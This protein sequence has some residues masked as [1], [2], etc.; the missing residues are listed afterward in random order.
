ML[1]P[2]LSLEYWLPPQESPTTSPESWL[3]WHEVES[4]SLHCCW[5][6]L[7][8]AAGSHT[9]MARAEDLAMVVELTYGATGAASAPAL[10]RMHAAAMRTHGATLI[11][12]IQGANCHCAQ[13][14]GSDCDG[15]RVSECTLYTSLQGQGCGCHLR[16]CHHWW[17]SFCLWC[18]WGS[19]CKNQGVVH[20]HQRR[21]DG[22]PPTN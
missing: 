10:T 15:T 9:T 12:N 13:R 4:F 8:A 16:K 17:Q 11:A 7:A 19:Q 5:S 14:P 3:W 6:Y 22:S 2:R 1:R 18:H 21:Q 20:G